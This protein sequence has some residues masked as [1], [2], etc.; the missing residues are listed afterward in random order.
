MN[1]NFSL[2]KIISTLSKTLNTANQI[3]PIYKQIKPYINK[4][5]S[6]INNLPNKN[7]LNA[8]NYSNSTSAN[9]SNNIKEEYNDGPTY[10]Q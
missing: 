1:N 4:T 2:L 3:I 9:K 5:T 8:F 10:F 7:I 6:F